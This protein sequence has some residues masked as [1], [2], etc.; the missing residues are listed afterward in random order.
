[1][2]A[3]FD[4]RQ[5]REPELVDQEYMGEFY[6]DDKV[7]EDAALSDAGNPESLLEQIT[8]AEV[9]QSLEALPAQYRSAVLLAD[10][11]G[12]SYK[13]IVHT[14]YVPGVSR[15]PLNPMKVCA[16]RTRCG[17]SGP[18]R[19]Q[20]SSVIN[21][22]AARFQRVDRSSR[23]PALKFPSAKNPTP[24][25]TNPE[26]TSVVSAGWKKNGVISPQPST[27]RAKK[28]A[29]GR[30]PSTVPTIGFID[31]EAS[32]QSGISR[33]RLLPHPVVAVRI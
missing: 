18:V 14:G 32:R 27:V 19:S 25:S 1:M 8:D 6:L 21:P 22:S 29:R 33:S 23:C 3:F 24:A 16:H 28:T 31:G 15:P 7:S 13:E 10:V 12:F 30:K 26:I 4:A 20:G 11:E 9:R 17:R 2:N 5:S